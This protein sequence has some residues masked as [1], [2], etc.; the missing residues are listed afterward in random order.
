[1][2][3][4]LLLLRLVHVLGGVFWVGSGIFTSLFLLP[5]LAP[6]GPAAGQVLAN[7][8]KRRLFVVLPTVAVLTML[9]GARLMMIASAGR[10][11]Y[12][13]SRSGMTYSI[14]AAA[15]VAGFLLSLLVARPGSVRIGTLSQQA[16]SDPANRDRLA[17]EISVI[18]RR[19]Q[20]SSVAAMAFLIFAA[21]GMAVARYL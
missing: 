20:T 10:S 21:A 16:A 1:M 18:Q 2:Q 7:L 14:A 6:T 13:A 12:F 19:V 15:A 4:E 9:S 11:D 8:T 17:A 5:A 3:G